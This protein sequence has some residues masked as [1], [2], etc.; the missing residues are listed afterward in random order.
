MTKYKESDL[1]LHNVIHLK[2]K[3]NT[4]NKRTTKNK[5]IATSLSELIYMGE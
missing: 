2:K 4:K 3:K 5:H 1:N